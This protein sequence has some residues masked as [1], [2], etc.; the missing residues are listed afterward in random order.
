MSWRSEV[1]VV[2]DIGSY[3]CR[4]GYAGVENPHDV[5]RTIIGEKRYNEIMVGMECRDKYVCFEALCM[6]GIL[7]LSYPIERGVVTNWDGM[8][9]IWDHIYPNSL[10]TNP[11]EHAVLLSESPFNPTSNRECIAELLFEKYKVPAVCFKDPGSMSL[12]AS[13]RTTGCVLDCGDG[14]STVT[15]IY[16]GFLIKKGVVRLDLGGR[17]VTQNLATNLKGNPWCS[18]LPNS[19]EME[20]IGHIKEKLGYVAL[21]FSQ[22]LN[23]SKRNWI[24]KDF[25]LPDGNVFV[26]ED[27]MF[28]SSEVLFQ[29]S[30]IG[31]N[32][33]GLHTKLFN[34]IM[35]CDMDS[36]RDLFANLVVSGGVSMTNGFAARLSKELT[37]L[38][39]LNLRTKVISPPERLYA[40]WIG[41]SILASL[42]S[43]QGMFF[44]KSEYDEV[45][46]TITHDKLFLDDSETNYIPYSSTTNALKVQVAEL[47]VTIAGLEKQI[48]EKDAAH[49]DETDRLM[50]LLVASNQDVIDRDQAIEEIHASSQKMCVICLEERKSVVLVPC[51][52]FCLCS[53]C[54]VTY[55]SDVCPACRRIIECK[56]TLFD[57]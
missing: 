41:G 13:G 8:E 49:K 16:G 31:M 50:S 21:D 1:N 52:H 37:A 24:G 20:T 10:R 23:H 33:S 42:S 47:E 19:A 27:E 2:M 44:S 36:R 56:V 25:Q 9:K 46:P 57:A 29:P 11:E 53:G 12:Y 48:Q 3:S 6:R 54:S 45:G 15:P 34:S 38:T 18:S 7:D 4:T 35:L 43:F 26:I 39:P 5:T 22:E 32:S 51:G 55:S 40:V 28:R 14:V 17:D 30:L